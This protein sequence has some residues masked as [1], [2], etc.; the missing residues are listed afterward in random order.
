MSVFN[1]ND[2][3]IQKINN[4]VSN[5]YDKYLFSY[6]NVVGFGFAQKINSGIET[7][8][9]SLTFLVEKK[10]SIDQL[11]QGGIIP[12][13]I[14]GIKT[15]VIESGKIEYDD[16]R[17]CRNN[18]CCGCDGYQYDI[19]RCGYLTRPVMGGMP[20]GIKG[21]I[22]TGT[23]ACAVV[24]NCSVYLL[25]NNHVIGN[26]NEAPVGSDVYSPGYE[27]GGFLTSPIAKLL[28]VKEVLFKDDDPNN[29]NKIDAAIAYVGNINNPCVRRIVKQGV[30]LI[31]PICGVNYSMAVGDIVKKV[32]IATLY[33]SGKVISTNFVVSV[34]S[35][36]NGKTAIFTDQIAANNFNA[37]GDSGSLGLDEKNRA[38]GV[39]FA[40]A[41]N[42][43]TRLSFYN[44]IK[45]VLS[46]F[47]VCIW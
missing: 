41:D 46:E 31:G 39:L 22:K 11:G 44:P 27:N 7:G 28:E 47:N 23:I 3:I 30:Y 25:G 35:P 2:P 40:G 15:D 4:I 32:G 18:I 42:G 16:C 45:E 6:P 24:K 13:E 14:E 19:E 29:V 21:G 26:F 1:I 34:I 36:N 38:F 17:C 12:N 33:T 20:F 9:P 10:V 8:I 5:M 43:D 37:K